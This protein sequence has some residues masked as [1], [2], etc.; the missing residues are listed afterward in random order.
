MID[1][2]HLPRAYHLSG[3]MLKSPYQLNLYRYPEGYELLHFIWWHWRGRMRIGT[4]AVPAPAPPPALLP[5]CTLQ[6]TLLAPPSTDRLC[7]QLMIMNLVLSWPVTPKPT[8]SR[9]CNSRRTGTYRSPDGSW[10]PK[11]LTALIDPRRV[12]ITPCPSRFRCFSMCNFQF[13]KIIYFAFNG[14]VDI[15]GANYN[16]ELLH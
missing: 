1:S 12:T 9:L 10:K 6:D 13:R 11:Q 16:V 8:W 7:C 15:S 4:Q 14:I 3:S 2:Y 5:L